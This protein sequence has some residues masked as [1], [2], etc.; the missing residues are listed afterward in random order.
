MTGPARAPQPAT[1]ALSWWQRGV[2]YQI[3]PR[4]FADATG[5]GVGDLC[6]IT[7]RLG[8]LAWLGVDAVWISPIYPS[9]MADFGYDI[10]D[11]T[12]IDPVFGTLEDFDALIAEAHRVGLRVLLDY[13]P[14]HTSIE[15]PWFAEARASRHSTRRD[16][17][18]WRDPAPDGGP[19]NNWRSV[20]GGSAWTLDQMSGQCYYH[21]YLPEQPDL[22]WRHPPVR[23]AMFDVLRCWL[24]RGVAGFRVDALRHLVKD[25]RWR[26][27]PP[28]PEFRRGEPPYGALLPVHAADRDDVHEP[29]A[30][31][32]AVLREHGDPAEERLL[33]GE[34]YV[35]IER[36]VRYYGRDG[37]GLQLPSNMHLIATA[38]EPEAIV[39]LIE[40][41]EA[42]LPA[43][44]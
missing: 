29:I 34:L 17:Y 40:R 33:I 1:D 9:P 5:D 7:E 19:P 2:V 12:A 3:Y 42:T 4:S 23:E 13:V 6:G 31:M 8:Y 10:T 41:Y 30:A 36:L 32:R 25:P 15:H 24:D 44:A 35:P 14:N 43:G 39:A 20:F 11:H 27:N 28:N 22:N 21:A 37:A 18:L 26:D 16:W 38:W